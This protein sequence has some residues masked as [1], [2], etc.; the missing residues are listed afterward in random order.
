MNRRDFIKSAGMGAAAVSFNPM[1]LMRRAPALSS[2]EK[3]ALSALLNW[4]KSGTELDAIAIN[5]IGFS[6]SP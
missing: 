3:S 5:A 6:G 4:E 1:S 2:M